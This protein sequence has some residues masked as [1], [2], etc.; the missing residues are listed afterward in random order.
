MS[1]KRIVVGI[2][3]NF[4]LFLALTRFVCIGLY[5]NGVAIT[6]EIQQAELVMPLVL[7]CVVVMYLIALFHALVTKKEVC[8][9]VDAMRLITIASELTICAVRLGLVM[10][11]RKTFDI[12]GVDIYTFIVIPLL[13]FISFLAT[14]KN[15]SPLGLLYAN[16]G[17]V[18]YVGTIVTLVVLNK[19][20]P[21]YNFIDVMNQKVYKSVINGVIILAI[22]TVIAGIIMLITRYKRVEKR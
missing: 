12:T 21:P 5:G 11:Y 2:I 3:L 13:G 1:R 8:K 18:A 10:P 6:K 9:F 16:L 20:N 22:N 4:I 17:V 19:I 7:W 14:K 15:Y